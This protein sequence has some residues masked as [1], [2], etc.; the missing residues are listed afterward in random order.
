M[1]LIYIIYIDI[2][3]ASTLGLWCAI[4]RQTYFEIPNSVKNFIEIT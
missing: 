4:Q 3:F 2:Y 1:K